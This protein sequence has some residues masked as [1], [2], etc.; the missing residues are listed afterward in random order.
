MATRQWST[1]RMAKLPL[2][3]DTPGT[4]TP[5]STLWRILKN[6]HHPLHQ[7]SP[8]DV[9]IIFNWFWEVLG[10]GASFLQKLR[11]FVRCYIL[12][13]NNGPLRCYY[14]FFND[15][16]PIGKG[17]LQ[18]HRN[19]LGVCDGKSAPKNQRGDIFCIWMVKL[20]CKIG[21]FTQKSKFLK[22]HCYENFNLK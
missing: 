13:N 16:W 8:G 3:P 11:N 21:F 4:K 9:Y 19:V 6:H 2:M 1:S 7:K 5:S 12:P 18:A 15:N 10:C 20:L 22:F 17:R 14:S